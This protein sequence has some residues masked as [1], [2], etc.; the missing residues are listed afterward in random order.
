MRGDENCASVGWR[1]Q[2]HFLQ[3]RLFLPL[4]G[5]KG[6][7]FVPTRASSTSD[8]RKPKCVASWLGQRPARLL[9]CLGI[10][11][12]TRRQEEQ[13]REQTQGGSAGRVQ[14]L[15]VSGSCSQSSQSREERSSSFES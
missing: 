1:R 8:Q 7:P 14:N 3:L 9:L 10:Y 15:P 6:M 2:S 5:G 12:R 13:S 11:T 4:A